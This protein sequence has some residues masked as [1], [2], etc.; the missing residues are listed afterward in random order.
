VKFKQIQVTT[1]KT[2]ELTTLSSSHHIELNPSEAGLYD[3]VVVQQVIKEIADSTNID[4]KFPF[5]VVLL[6][7]VDKLSKDAQNALRRTMEKYM[8]NCRL[9]LCCESTCRLI[10]PLRSRC[11]AIRIASPTEA[12]I[13]TVLQNIATEE[14]LKLPANLASRIAANCNR[15]MR[16]AILMLEASKTQ[17]YP[18][19]ENQEIQ[20]PDW[21]VFIDELGRTITEEQSPARLLLARNKVY[22]L[23]T[24]CIPAE[25]VLK[26]LAQVLLKRVDEQ[27]KKDVMKYAAFYDH[28]LKQGSKAIFH[29]EAFIAKFMAIYKKFL[30]EMFFQ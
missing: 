16:R 28:R 10:E 8:G 4:Q 1:A 13:T 18:F 22:E 25:V 27:I 3:R 19:D 26:T 21:E 2:I 29:I 7:E 14:K 15:N 5:K 9:I 23:L 24:N 6:N 17:Q 20:L 12:E 11:L 30:N